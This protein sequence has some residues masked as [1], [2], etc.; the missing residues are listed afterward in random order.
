[1]T[2][3]KVTFALDQATVERLNGL[4][5]QLGK[6]KSEIMREAIREYHQRHV[7]NLGR[8]ERQ[9]IPSPPISPA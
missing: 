2:T 3:T 9:R 8:S 6:T 5:Q 7:A 1:M 4:A